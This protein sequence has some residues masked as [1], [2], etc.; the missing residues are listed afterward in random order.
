MEKSVTVDILEAD[1][2]E[3]F[4]GPKIATVYINAVDDYRWFQG[5]YSEVK[6]I[7]RW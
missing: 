5:R 2:V 6:E 3:E 7:I 1:K 4:A